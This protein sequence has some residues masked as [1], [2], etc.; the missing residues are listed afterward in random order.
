MC[1][2][3]LFASMLVSKS[4]VT[5]G[6]SHVKK[7]CCRFSVSSKWCLQSLSKCCQDLCLHSCFGFR[8]KRRQFRSVFLSTELLLQSDLKSLQE[9][10]VSKVR[11]CFDDDAWFS[12]PTLHGFEKFI[13][14]TTAA[15]WC[16]T[17]WELDPEGEPKSGGAG[18]ESVSWL[19]LAVSGI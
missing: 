10:G 6:V 13:T 19:E 16:G 1:S 5:V 14:I 17:R 18:W 7:S 3:P 15:I 4:A 11:V 2:H 9:G 8:C 12:V